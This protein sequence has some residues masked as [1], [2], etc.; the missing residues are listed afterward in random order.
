MMVPLDIL[1]PVLP[2]FLRFMCLKIRCVGFPCP[3]IPAVAFILDHAIDRARIP[4][5]VTKLCPSSIAGEQVSDLTGRPSIEIQVIN[6]LHRFRLVGIDHKVT[7]LIK[8]VPK[9]LRCQEDAF[10]EPALDRPVHD[11]RLRP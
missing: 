11:E 4:Y 8:I 5:F 10:A 6:H 9:K 1:L 2:V 3:H 7:V